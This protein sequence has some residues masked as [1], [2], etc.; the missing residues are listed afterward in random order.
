[1]PGRTS[2]SATTVVRP[3][4]DRSTTVVRA[5]TNRSTPAP[6]PE[7]EP[8]P[9]DPPPKPP[10]GGVSQDPPRPRPSNRAKS[11]P[12]PE[13]ER[14]WALYPRRV[15]R[16]AAWQAWN[17]CLSGG[18]GAPPP[19]GAADLIGAAASY[20]RECR[21]EGREP[22]VTLHASTFLGPQRRW[23]DYVGAAGLGLA[24]DVAPLRQEAPE[25]GLPV[26]VGETARGS[27]EGIGCA[28]PDAETR[29]LKARL[30]ARQAA[31]RRAT[32]ADGA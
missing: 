11:Q 14:F 8:E 5:S 17:R 15:A 3:Y 28:D 31:E 13:F 4:N 30:A 25:V 12:S 9:K 7:P 20:A 10:Q 19:G 16:D 29:G 18:H 27:P 1:M 26:R 24:E 23:T 32:S 2:A 21:S 22:R 6:A